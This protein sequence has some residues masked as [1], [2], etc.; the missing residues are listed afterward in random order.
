MAQARRHPT[1]HCAQRTGVNNNSSTNSTRSI[2]GR[3][4]AGIS[5]YTP[6][7]DLVCSQAL[8]SDVLSGIAGS[9]S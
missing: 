9:A 4:F 7:I 2:S 8:C 6:R 1:L 5:K 3:L